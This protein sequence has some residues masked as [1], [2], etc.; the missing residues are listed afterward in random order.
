MVIQLNGMTIEGKIEKGYV[1][2]SSLF[3]ATD[4][5]DITLDNG[6]K[7]IYPNDQLFSD[8]GKM[9]IQRGP[10]VYCAE[11]VDNDE[12]VFSLVL[13][14]DTEFE[15]TMVEGI[16][17]AI[18]FKAMSIKRKTSAQLYDYREPTEIETDVYLI[19]YYTWGNRGLNQMRVWL[20]YS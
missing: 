10:V 18:G 8:S 1:Y 20:P 15:E 3:K 7:K 6:V 19:P 14:R 16:G 12:D 13:K 17:E 2:I 9:A 5:I 4:I 11:G